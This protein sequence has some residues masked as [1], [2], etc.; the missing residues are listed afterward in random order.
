VADGQALLAGKGLSGNPHEWSTLVDRLGGNGLALK[1]VGESIR[2]LFGGQLE[3]FLDEAG[4]GTLFG[5][6]RRLLTEQIERSS[7]LEQSVLRVLAVEREPVSITQLIAEIGS[8]VGRGAVLEA[9]ESLLRRS[10]VERADGADTRG[11]AAFTLQSVVLEYVTDRLVE[12]VSREI[13]SGTPLRLVRQPIIKAQSKDFVRRTQERLIGA[14][15]VQ[16]VE[17][18]SGPGATDQRLLTLLDSWRDHPHGEQGY[19]PGNVVNL[20]RLLRG[21]I[22]GLD[23]SHLSIRH[24]YLQEV[25]AQDAS[26]AAAHLSET[27]LAAAFNYPTAVALSADGVH[28]TVGTSTGEVYLWRVPNRMLLLA[29]QGHDGTVPG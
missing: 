20:L 24:A 17:A 25:E 15:I 11:H 4:S 7:A 8:R 19:G 14:P 27:V 5:G 23:L 2:E 9:T 29:V 1:V 13:A 6:I 28:L 12:E 21:D 3:A 10:L 16:R 18:N 26:L 22:R